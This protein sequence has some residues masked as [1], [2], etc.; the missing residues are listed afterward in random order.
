M[1]CYIAGFT[2]GNGDR[3]EHFGSMQ[4]ISQGDQGEWLPW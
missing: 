3:E 4:L 2:K 1:E